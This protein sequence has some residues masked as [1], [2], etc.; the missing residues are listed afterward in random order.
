MYAEVTRLAPQAVN[1]HLPTNLRLSTMIDEEFRVEH[2]RLDDRT[3][4]YW[5]PNISSVQVT[6]MTAAAKKA[7]D[8]GV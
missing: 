6:E 4:P 2:I 7:F 5:L 1:V 8:E 3:L